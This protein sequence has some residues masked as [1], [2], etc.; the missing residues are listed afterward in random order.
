MTLSGVSIVGLFLF[1][2]FVFARLAS[3]NRKFR[4]KNDQKKKKKKKME[5]REYTVIHKLGVL[6]G[7]HNIF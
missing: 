1:L 5:V 3:A 7:S 2:D 6:W 4:K